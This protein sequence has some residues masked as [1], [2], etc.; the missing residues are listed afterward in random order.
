MRYRQILEELQGQL[1]ATLAS[2]EV[3]LE[4]A[5]Q[6]EAALEAQLT[7]LIDALHVG[8]REEPAKQWTHPVRFQVGRALDLIRSHN[9]IR[10]VDRVIEEFQARPPQAPSS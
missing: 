8:L 2:M 9:A 6:R 1:G 5:T 4:L 10:F 7:T 3:E